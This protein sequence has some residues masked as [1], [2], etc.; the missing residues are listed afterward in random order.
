MNFGIKFERSSKLKLFGNSKS[1]WACCIDDKK[2]TFR[3]CVFSWFMSVFSWCSKKLKIM[4][5][6][7]ADGEYVACNKLGNS[8]S[9]LVEKIHEKC[10]G[11][12]K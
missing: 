8:T 10:R 3:L 6:W 12:A 2:N 4:A 11:E 7:S 9:N 5:Q 1:D